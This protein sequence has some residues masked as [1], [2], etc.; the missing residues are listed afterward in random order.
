MTAAHQ[1]GY[2]SKLRNERHAFQRHPASHFWLLVYE[3]EILVIF[4]CSDESKLFFLPMFRMKPAPDAPQNQLKDSKLHNTHIS[5]KFVIIL[6]NC[7]ALLPVEGVMS[8]DVA[9]LHFRWKSCKIFYAFITLLAAIFTLT[10]GI[11]YLFWTSS[12][13]MIGETKKICYIYS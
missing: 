11:I 4:N 10:T 12:F 13:E 8:N 3:H 1:R 2:I 6:A 5:L 9:E 7:F